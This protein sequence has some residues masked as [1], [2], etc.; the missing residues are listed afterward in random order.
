MKKS[1]KRLGIEKIALHT[2]KQLPECEITPSAY[3]RPSCDNVNDFG[4]M[5]TPRKK[6]NV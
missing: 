6:S 5:V 2:R 1:L 4:S 3:L